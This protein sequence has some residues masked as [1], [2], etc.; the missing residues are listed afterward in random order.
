MVCECGLGEVFNRRERRP[1]GTA[2]LVLFHRTSV[3]SAKAIQRD[4]FLDG[5]GTYGTCRETTGVWLSN[6]PLDMNEGATPGPLLRITLRATEQELAPYEWVEEDKPYREWQ[7]P[8]S[9][10]NARS[11][12]EVLTEA[13]EDAVCEASLKEAMKRRAARRG[14][15]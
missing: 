14:G 10:I 15:K 6:M 7:V 11:S 13:E 8:A 5:V 9:F 2:A 1:A 12:I 3:A 4:G